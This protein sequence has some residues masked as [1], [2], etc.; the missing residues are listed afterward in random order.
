MFAQLFV[1]SYLRVFCVCFLVLR[2]SS[3]IGTISVS[4]KGMLG[5][6]CVMIA[7]AFTVQSSP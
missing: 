6:V 4:V 1:Q 7:L 2:N 3:R 5:E